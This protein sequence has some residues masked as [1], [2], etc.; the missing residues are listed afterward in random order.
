MLT[1]N[2]QFLNGL[3]PL[4]QGGT[5]VENW[6]DRSQNTGNLPLLFSILV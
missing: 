6:T 1:V 3:V 2:V 4:L 5:G